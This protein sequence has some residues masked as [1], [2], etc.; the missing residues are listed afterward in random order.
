MGAVRPIPLLTDNYAYL[1]E[2]PK[3]DWI[4]IDPSEA[5]P[6]IDLAKK[7]EKKIL[8]IFN[9]HPHWDHVGGNVEIQKYFDCPVVVPEGDRDRVKGAS[10]VFPQEGNFS[11]AGLDFHILSVPGH[12]LHSTAIFWEKEKALFTGDTLFLSG[13]GRVFEGTHEQMLRSLEKLRAFPDETLI[14]CGHEYTEQNLKFL[15]SIWPNKEELKDYQSEIRVFR[16]KKMA[17]VPGKMGLEKKMNPFFLFDSPE[18]ARRLG[19]P[20]A[21]ALEIFTDL[22]TR[23]DNF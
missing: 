3:K 23:K 19:K 14:Y 18:M 16:Q 9:T 12:T 11:F 22:R 21:S 2:T 15:A 20:G 17:T 7:E 13:C 10:E 8:G 4:V 6:L 5:S 1:L